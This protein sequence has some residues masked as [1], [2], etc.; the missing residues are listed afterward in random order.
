M[1]VF[2]LLIIIPRWVETSIWAGDTASHTIRVSS[3][4]FENQMCNTCAKIEREIVMQVTAAGGQESNYSVMLPG[5]N[6]SKALFFSLLFCLFLVQ[7]DM[8]GES[9][10]A[11][12]LSNNNIQKKYI[13]LLCW[14][15]SRLIIIY[16]FRPFMFI[17]LKLLHGTICT[18]ICLLFFFHLNFIY[19]KITILIICT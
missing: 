17:F 4:S 14:L 10:T 11:R 1:M 15:F 8:V 5:D 13:L 19:F 9:Y 16:N 18:L 12:E 3:C 2:S 6:N 7:I